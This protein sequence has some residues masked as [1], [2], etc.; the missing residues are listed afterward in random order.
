MPDGTC[1]PAT[2]GEAF[3]TVALAIDNGNVIITTRFGWDGVSVRPDCDGPVQDIR[4]QNL[5]TLTYY[6]NLPNKKRG[7][8]YLEILPG[9]D[10]TY[11]GNQ[12]RQAGLENFSDVQGVGLSTD[13]LML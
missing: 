13:P 2:R 8:R 4:V 3:N 5:S 12:L 1:D 7:N 6:A 9:T 11:S 10:R